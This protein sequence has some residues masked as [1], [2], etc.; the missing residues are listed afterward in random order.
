[1]RGGVNGGGEQPQRS[2]HNTGHFNLSY[3]SHQKS[4]LHTANLNR[5]NLVGLPFVQRT[6][7]VMSVGS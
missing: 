4:P 6:L 5:A 1:M 7:E 2:R 3:L